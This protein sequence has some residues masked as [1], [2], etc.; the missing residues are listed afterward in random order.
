MTFLRHLALA[1]AEAAFKAAVRE[2]DAELDRIVAN[3]LAR[4]DEARINAPGGRS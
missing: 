1:I 3:T 2:I 4:I